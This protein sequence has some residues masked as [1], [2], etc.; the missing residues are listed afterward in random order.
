MSAETRMTDL[1]N[2]IAARLGADEYF[3][4]I[5]VLTERKQD[6]ESEIERAL[7]VMAAKGGRSGVCVIVLNPSA[8]V[9]F[10]NSP[11]PIFEYSIAVKVTEL[12]LV[13]QGAGGTGKMAASIATRVVQNLY[14]YQAAGFCGLLEALDPVIVP[15]EDEKGVACLVRF[16]TLDASTA[17]TNKVATPAITATADAHPSAVTLACDTPGAQIYYTLDRSHPCP[18]NAGAF[19]YTAPFAVNTAAWVRAGAFKTD[20]INSD[21]N[22]KIIL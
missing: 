22:L 2:E 13:N 1:Q 21:I 3:S 16:K 8:T 14:Q 10:Q 17:A 9:K 5:T 18:R 7:G 20:S 6:V 4:D 12:P 19:L 11:E 15:E